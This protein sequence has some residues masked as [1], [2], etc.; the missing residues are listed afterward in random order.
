MSKPDSAWRVRVSRACR[1]AASRLQGPPPGPT[2]DSALQRTPADGTGFDV[3]LDRHI[4][5]WLPVLGPL[6]GAFVILF[7]AWDA[8]IDPAH[9]R[10]SLTWR[11]ILVTAGIPA[12]ADTRLAVRTRCLLLY[13]THVGAMTAAAGLLDHG[14]LLALPALTGAPL[15]L[16][17]IE[18]RPRRWLACTLAPALLFLALAARALPPADFLNGALLYALAW[19][20][21]GAVAAIHL[22]LWRR[23]Y[24][25]EQALL[26]ASR[27]D[28]LSGALSRGYLTE[29][30][31]R[32]I[33]LARRHGRPL[34]I[35][36][37]DID[38]FKHVNDTHGHDIGDRVL[39]AM[40]Q[41]CTAGMRASDYF[42]R[43]GGEEFV[44]VMPEASTADALA[45][46]ERMRTDI[47][48]L[49]VPTDAGPLHI[50]VSLGVAVLDRHHDSWESLLR[51]ADAALYR[52]KETGRNRSVLAPTPRPGG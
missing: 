15:V 24:L 2:P 21:A 4:A 27:Y 12:Y 34:A 25:A 44:C 13:V 30:A 1:A 10:A 11:L 7:S 22:R 6:L 41:T 46:A 40:A 17:L 19:L 20:L 37:L 47:A 23:T 42:G 9:A 49:A 3:Q 14:M 31:A 32:D 52:A 8:W 26:R 16:A 45:C 36:M 43:I 33:A 29:L 38:F 50:T 5:R 39:A 28:S 18:P 48:A 35:A 51:A